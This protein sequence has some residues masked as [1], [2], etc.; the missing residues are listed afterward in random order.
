MFDTKPK[1]L[2]IAPGLPKKL[3]NDVR[4]I[5]LAE[6]SCTP[7]FYRRGAVISSYEVLESARELL[8]QK[9]KGYHLTD[10]ERRL[11]RYAIRLHRQINQLPNGKVMDLSCPRIKNKYE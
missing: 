2:K 9:Q 3:G 1:G 7:I 4:K 6:Y 11:V 8:Q 10:I 5:E